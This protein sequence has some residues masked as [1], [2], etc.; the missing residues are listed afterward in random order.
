VGREPAVERADRHDHL[1]VCRDTM[2]PH[3]LADPQSHF[4]VL[5]AHG[6]LNGNDAPLEPGHR[7]VVHQAGIVLG[8]RLEGVDG[9]EVAEEDAGDGGAA[10]VRADVD[11]RPADDVLAH[12]QDR[13]EG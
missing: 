11:H 3:P 2:Q 10:D 8:L 12:A 7:D 9:V 5:G 1:A 13:P 4:T 6:R